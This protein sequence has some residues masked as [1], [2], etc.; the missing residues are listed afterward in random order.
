MSTV[1]GTAEIEARLTN[2]EGVLAGLRQVGKGVADTATQGERA[3]GVF[4][5]AGSALSGIVRSGL[6]VAGVFQAIDLSRATDQFRQLDLVS[7]RFAQAS[8]QGVADLQSRFIA[9]EAKTLTAAPA[10]ASMAQSLGR[11]TYD[12]RAAAG[13]LADLSEYAQATGQQLTDVGSSF[14]ALHQGL[15]VTERLGDEL[16]RVRDIA[17]QLGTKGGH[18]ALVDTLTALGPQLAQVNT[19]TDGARAKLEALVGVLGK[20]LKPQQAQQV[21]GGVLSMLKEK[22]FDIER[23]TGKQVIDRRTGQLIDPTQ[24]LRNLQALRDR[25]GGSQAVKEA[26]AV[27][28]YGWDIGMALM[29]T[30]FSQ[31][32]R[33]AQTSTKNRQLQAGTTAEE[34]ARFRQTEAA[35]RERKR[36]A[37][38]AMNRDVGGRAITGFTDKVHDALGTTGLFASGIIGGAAGTVSSGLALPKLAMGVKSLLGLG[39]ATGAEGAAATAA[40]EGAGAAG[41]SSGGLLSNAGAFLMSGAGLMSGSFIGAAALQMKTLTEIG[42]DRDTMGQRWRAEHAQVQ[43]SELASQALQAGDLASVVGKAGGD[44]EV[45]VSML[46]TLE[47]QFG[48]LNETL[49]TQVAAGIAAELH[50]APIVVRPAAD[51][52]KPTASGSN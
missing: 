13:A 45:L 6:A 19:E 41:T 38:E 48:E 30:D 14:A 49:R 28:T 22:A 32:D 1:T 8:G 4:Q 47:K 21:A 46:Q 31:V 24:T 16:G 23:A 51:P 34:A 40:A 20:G 37:L 39:G 35:E 42:E 26:R 17:Q 10:M 15:G 27:N 43:G 50:R 52:N 25:Q 18:V 36:L 9:L 44:R 5:S 33:V 7:T 12:G 29:R 11:A 2:L 3:R